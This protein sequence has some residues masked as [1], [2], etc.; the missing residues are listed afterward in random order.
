M[1][2][3]DHLNRLHNLD[4]FTCRDCCKEFKR[5]TVEFFI[6]QGAWDIYL[7]LVERTSSVLAGPLPDKLEN[8]KRKLG[9]VNSKTEASEAEKLLHECEMLIQ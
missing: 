3:C 2:S 1:E 8:L 9:E 7:A 5:G 6:Y 4:G